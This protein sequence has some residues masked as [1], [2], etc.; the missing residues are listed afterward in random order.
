MSKWLTFLCFLQ[1]LT[2]N[3]GR[4]VDK[5]LENPDGKPIGGRDGEDFF[6]SDVA[7]VG[8]DRGFLCGIS[9]FIPS[10]NITLRKNLHFSWYI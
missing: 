10:L 9:R 5:S 8:V 6:F 4:S 7:R 2:V 3:A 1:V